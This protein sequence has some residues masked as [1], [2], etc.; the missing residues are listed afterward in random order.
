MSEA[1]SMTRLIEMTELR[2]FPRPVAEVKLRR[3]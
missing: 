3:T 2:L 1:W